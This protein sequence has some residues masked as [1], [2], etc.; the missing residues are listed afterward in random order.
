M[1]DFDIEALGLDDLVTAGVPE[2]D[3]AAPSTEEPVGRVTPEKTLTVEEA[4]ELEIERDLT[5]PAM[6]PAEE[7]THHYTFDEDFQAKIAAMLLRDTSFVQRTEGLTSPAYFEN[8]YDQIIA[9]LCNSYFAKYRKTPGDLSVMK[10]IVRKGVITKMLRREELTGVMG[11]VRELLKT[12]ISDRDFVVEEVATFARYQAV[13]KAILE[14]VEHLDIGEFDTIAMKMRKALDTGENADVGGYDYGEMLE[15]RTEERIAKASGLR[16]PTGITT[17][18]P[19][20][21]RHL[22]HRGWGRRELSVLMGPAK[23]GKTTALISFALE[24]ARAGHNVLYVT[25]EVAAS[26]IADRMDANIAGVPMMDL[27]GHPHTIAGEVAEFS[28]RAGRF[29]LVEYP[30]G[31]MKVSDLRRIIEREKAKGNTFDLVV[32]DYADLMQ[33]ERAT[34]SS[35]EN[36]KSVYVNLRGLAMMEGFAILTAT[37]TNREGAKKAVVTMTDVA[38]DFNKIRIADIVISI[39]KTDD[40]RALNEARLFFAACR[41]QAGGFSVRIKQDTECMRFLTDVLG[42]E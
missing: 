1:D 36:S 22:Y 40:E 33:P 8:P 2:P 16:P 14:S 38:E 34:E 11:R 13:S 15:Y 10:A 29:K 28:K 12:D 23:A 4:A 3:L 19:E 41:N 39:N 31:M 18:F 21:D 9:H 42:E 25:L 27:N 37:Q 17:G 24:A 30:T 20:L 32:V 6:E 5:I 35:V 7:G 26:I